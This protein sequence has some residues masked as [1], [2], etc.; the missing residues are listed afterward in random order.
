MT[1]LGIKQYLPLTIFATLKVPRGAQAHASTGRET[2]SPADG[3]KLSTGQQLMVT[4]RDLL[5][6]KPH[7]FNLHTNANIFI[8]H[9]S[10]NKVSGYHLP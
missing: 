3:F 8:R 1:H 10:V 9:K 2:H 6:N 5:Q 4:H 7:L